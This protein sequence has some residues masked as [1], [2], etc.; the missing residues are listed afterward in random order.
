MWDEITCPFPNFNGAAVEVYE[1]ISNI[2]PYFTGHMDTYPCPVGGWW[3]RDYSYISV[4]YQNGGLVES[5]LR[6]GIS[7]HST[8]VCRWTDY[9]VLIENVWTVLLV[10]SLLYNYG[11]SLPEWISYDLAQTSVDTMT[12]QYR[13]L[14]YV[15]D[16]PLENEDSP[17]QCVTI[18]CHR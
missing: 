12:Y 8:I 10:K 18:T 17:S 7:R 2:I 6:M 14:E 3:G 9:T 11:K 4:S 16:A 15:C 13:W 5:K 1:W